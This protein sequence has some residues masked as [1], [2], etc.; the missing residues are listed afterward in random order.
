[1]RRAALFALLAQAAR[2][3]GKECRSPNEQDYACLKCCNDTADGCTFRA[4]SC[5]RDNTAP[6]CKGEPWYNE[7]GKEPG[8][9]CSSISCGRR[10]VSVGSLWE[11]RG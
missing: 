6:W 5:G 4:W 10:P 1:M 8:K 11:R 3:L 9:R 7:G 2:T